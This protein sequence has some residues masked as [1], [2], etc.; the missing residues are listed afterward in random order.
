MQAATELFAL[1]STVDPT[2]SASAVL[3]GDQIDMA[4]WREARFTMLVGAV[5]S[6]AT[7][8][9]DIYGGAASGTPSAVI[10]GKQSTTLT[11][12]AASLL[13]VE[14]RV[15]AEEVAAQ[16]YRYLT[17]YLTVGATAGTRIAMVGYGVHPRYGPAD[18]QDISTVTEIIT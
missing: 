14:I 12:T 8:A 5:T 2:T 1:L 7:V 10:T 15:T 17:P 4:D 3:T 11:G 6:T 13:Q 18:A 16:G 9:L